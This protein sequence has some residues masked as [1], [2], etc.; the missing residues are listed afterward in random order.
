MKKDI[1]D[2]FEDLTPSCEASFELRLNNIKENAKGELDRI[3][4]KN[5]NLQK[6]KKIEWLVIFNTIATIGGFIVGIISLFK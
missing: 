1:K 2:T 3:H 4:I 6:Y 5:K